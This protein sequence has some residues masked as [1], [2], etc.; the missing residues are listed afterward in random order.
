MD[1]RLFL[2]DGKRLGSIQSQDLPAVATALHDL[3]RG[4]ARASSRDKAGVRYLYIEGSDYSVS[5]LRSDWEKIA[6]LVDDGTLT[7][8]I[9]GED[10]HSYIL[11]RLKLLFPQEWPTSSL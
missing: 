10:T 4:L 7:T 1:S 8:R 6:P 11:G 3:A 9:C 2:V 5:I